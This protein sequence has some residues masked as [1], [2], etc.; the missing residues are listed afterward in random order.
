MSQ[1]RRD[2]RRT[3]M[4]AA[5]ILLL[6]GAAPAL[7][8]QPASPVPPPPPLVSPEVRPDLRVTFRFR[9]PNAKEVAV[10]REGAPKLA[11]EKDAQGIW[12][13]T[14]DPL[15]ADIYGY[16]FVA[17]GVRLVD[18]SNAVMIPNLLNKSSALYVPG[19]PPQPWELTD[20]PRGVLHRH[21]YR[22]RVVGD[23]RDF[24]VYTPPGYD[25]HESKRYP[26]L[27]LLHGFSDDASAWSE[28]GRASCRERV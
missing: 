4:A 25:P 19:N 14:T 28:I 23:D 8:A 24:Y 10:D 6:G 18:P 17:D 11:M 5:V 22:S 20:A 13:V 9:A 15:P 26:V 7:R 2:G 21:F 16:S 1:G 12:S 3:L 27:Y